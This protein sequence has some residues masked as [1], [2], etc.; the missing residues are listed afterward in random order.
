MAR[1]RFMRHVALMRGLRNI[2]K[3]KAVN[4]KFYGEM[5]G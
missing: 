2:Y 5:Q 1:F 4:S 3:F